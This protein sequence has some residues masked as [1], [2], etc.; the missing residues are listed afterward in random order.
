MNC[1]IHRQARGQISAA[2][3][4]QASTRRA[5]PSVCFSFCICLIL[6]SLWTCSPLSRRQACREPFHLQATARK[7][8]AS[9]GRV[10]GWSGVHSKIG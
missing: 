8:E 4:S 9:Q 5:A 1:G 2:A 3:Q 7:R 10:S 6:L